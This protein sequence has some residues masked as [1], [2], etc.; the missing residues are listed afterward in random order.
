[1]NVFE[2]KLDPPPAEPL[3]GWEWVREHKND[4]YPEPRM[5]IMVDG[6]EVANFGPRAKREAIRVVVEGYS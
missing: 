1:M 4:E 2:N 3:C 6:Q 5:V